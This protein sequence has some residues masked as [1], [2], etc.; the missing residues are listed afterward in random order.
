[1]WHFNTNK[2]KEKPT[3][4]SLDDLKAYLV[5]SV[6]GDWA[7][8][9][10]EEKGIPLDSIIKYEQAFKMLHAQRIDVL[11]AEKHIGRWYIN[12]LFPDETTS[13]DMFDKPF[14]KAKSIA[15]VMISSTYPDATQLQA[16][17]NQALQTIK[18][19]G[20]YQGILDKHGIAVPVSP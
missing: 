11:L 2:F 13:F 12:K 3:W 20:I 9:K 5:G 16:R 19:N 8:N 6:A 7:R 1:M 18:K 17:F 15:G 14:A 4:E 10:L